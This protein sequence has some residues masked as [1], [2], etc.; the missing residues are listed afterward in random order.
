MDRCTLFQNLTSLATVVGTVN[1]ANMHSGDFMLIEG[2]TADGRVF[3]MSLNVH[4]EEDQ[5]NGN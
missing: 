5:K 2:T 3:H 1:R 4:A